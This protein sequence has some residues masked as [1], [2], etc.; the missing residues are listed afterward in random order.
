MRMLWSQSEIVVVSKMFLIKNI[1]SK[2]V[3]LITSQ[4]PDETT[5]SLYGESFS[6]WY[7]S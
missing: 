7:S 3:I 2:L 4:L 5:H 1:P 6:L